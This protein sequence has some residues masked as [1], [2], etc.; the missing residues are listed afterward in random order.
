M[1]TPEGRVV[2]RSFAFQIFPRVSY[3][4]SHSEQIPGP[5]IAFNRFT[6]YTGKATVG[7]N[8][9][10]SVLPTLGPVITSIFTA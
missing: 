2:V 4:A 5:N 9:S 7:T 1:I 6:D 8:L 3:I 10:S